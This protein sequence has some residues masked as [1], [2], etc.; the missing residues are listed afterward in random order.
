MHPYATIYICLQL[1]FCDYKITRIVTC[2]DV[3]QES[4]DNQDIDRF[5]V[6]ILKH[7]AEMKESG[8]KG[9]AIAHS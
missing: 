6:D 3:V 9:V 2:V 5:S 1:I 7:R 8:K 4:E